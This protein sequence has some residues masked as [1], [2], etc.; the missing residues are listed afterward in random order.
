VEISTVTSFS[1][2]AL[3]LEGMVC[4]A[5]GT[6]MERAVASFMPVLPK[7]ATPEMLARAIAGERPDVPLDVLASSF[8]ATFLVNELLRVLVRELP[9][10]VVAPDLLVFDQDELTLRHWDAAGR[11]WRR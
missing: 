6:S 11:T 9:P 4:D 1:P 7:A 3:A 8:E 5:D 10:H 2:S